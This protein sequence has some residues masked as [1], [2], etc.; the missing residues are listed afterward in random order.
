MGK[1]CT[2]LDV[3]LKEFGIKG[4][5]LSESSGITDSAISKFRS[6]QKDLEL[7]T[8]EKLVDA[9]PRE[10][11]HYLFF[12]VLIGRANTEELSNFLHL[13]AKAI[14]EDQIS[15]RTEKELTPDR[16]LSLVS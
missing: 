5:Q 15:E 8:Y 9:L 4:R 16:E 10:A 6:G 13:I 3:T 1:F 7:G 12:K 11:Q 2:A 14:R